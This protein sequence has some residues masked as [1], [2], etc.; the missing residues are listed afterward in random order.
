LWMVRQDVAVARKGRPRKR[1][2][3][4]I[5]REREREFR[6]VAVVSKTRM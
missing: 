5:A 1:S 2:E 3:S 6:I 4:E